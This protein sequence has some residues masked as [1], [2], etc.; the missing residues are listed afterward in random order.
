[1]KRARSSNRRAI[2]LAEWLVEEGIGEHRAICLNDGQIAQARIAWPGE[3]TAGTVADAVLIARAAGAKRGTARLPDGE[4]ALVDNL[5]PGASEGAAIRLRITRPAMAERGRLKLAR[6]CPADEAPRP[7]PTLADGL[8][9][10]GHAVRVV[11]RFPSCDWDDLVQEA[12]AGEIAFAGGSLLLSPTPAMTLIDIDGALPPRDL[13][14]AAVP[15]IAGAILRLDLAGPIGIDFPTLATKADRRAVDISLQEHLSGW[16]H[17]R[18]AMNGF[19]FVQMVAR[20]ER[21]SILHRATLRRG[22][23]AAR[24]LLRRAE[25]LD[26]VGAIELSG[27]PA[28]EKAIGPQWMDELAVRTGR[29]IRWRADPGLALTAPHAQLVTP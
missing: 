11:H 24:L 18:T 13:A 3:L 19:G 12:F 4:E 20:M 16:A 21:A 25:R 15:A 28:L 23:M 14:L 7:A 1:M 9:R 29:M 26:G 6:A 27:H 10:E 22:G 2:P 5:P 17:E 8:A